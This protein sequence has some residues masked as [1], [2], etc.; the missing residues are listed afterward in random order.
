MTLT[1]DDDVAVELR[2][3]QAERRDAFKQTLNAVLRAGL[4]TL[5][6]REVE[7]RKKKQFRTE[8][9]S[10]GR[11]RLKNLDNISEVLAIAEGEEYP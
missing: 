7:G 6:R 4:Y 9:V 11:P 5:S 10:L 2:R 1:F 3:L 8:P